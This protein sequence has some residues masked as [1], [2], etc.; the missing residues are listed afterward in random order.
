MAAGANERVATERVCGS[1]GAAWIVTTVSWREVPIVRVPSMK[2]SFLKFL[3]ECC[4]WKVCKYFVLSCAAGCPELSR[5]LFL[6]KWTS[7]I[8]Q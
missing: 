2:Q 1:K 6:E 5:R 4:L 3:R 7:A 8:H